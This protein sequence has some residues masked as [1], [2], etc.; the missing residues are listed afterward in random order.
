MTTSTNRNAVVH[1]DDTRFIFRTNFSGDPA[2]DRFGSDKRQFNIVIPS[3]QQAHDLAMGGVNVRWTQP[4][5]NHTYDGEF[6]PKPF[7]RVNV[8]LESKWPPEVYLIAPNGVKTLLTPETIGVLDSIRVKNV[9]CQAKM[10]EKK[11]FPNQYALYAQYIYVEQAEDLY[12]DPYAN[13]Y[14]TVPE[15]DT[16]MAP[17]S[18]DDMPF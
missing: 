7:V 3:D 13:R 6:V 18:D 8:N 9:C 16:E 4:N 1:F 12:P 5:P 11:N 2:R 14:A 15:A 10:V 17:A